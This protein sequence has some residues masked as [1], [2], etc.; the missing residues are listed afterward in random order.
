[1]S[2]RPSAMASHKA[3]SQN[4]RIAGTGFAAIS[5]RFL[6]P[7]RSLSSKLG[8]EEV[9]PGI[10]LARSPVSGAGRDMISPLYICIKFA[11]ASSFSSASA[12]HHNTA[13]PDDR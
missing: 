11:P 10:T 1:M 12:A 8:H 7:A 5:S 13:Y 6:Q 9:C 2:A 4:T 3:D